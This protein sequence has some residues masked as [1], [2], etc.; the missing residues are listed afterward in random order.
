M[1]FPK[2]FI[3]GRR[4]MSLLLLKHASASGSG[5]MLLLQQK[6]AFAAAEA[7][8]N[9]AKHSLLLAPH[10]PPRR[11]PPPEVHMLGPAVSGPGVAVGG[12]PLGVLLVRQVSLGLFFLWYAAT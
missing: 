7:S 4:N 1:L 2:G 5:S 9:R 12:A 10:L 11:R 3:L 8:P 6:H